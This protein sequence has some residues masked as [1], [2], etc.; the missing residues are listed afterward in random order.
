MNE[1][2][3]IYIGGLE[4]YITSYEHILFREPGNI[5]IGCG[6]ITT[7]QYL[8][9]L[10]NNLGYDRCP[11]D[12]LW[13]ENNIDVENV[14]KTEV[15]D[16]PITRN[17]LMII[18]NC[19]LYTLLICIKNWIKGGMERGHILNPNKSFKLPCKKDIQFYLQN[20]VKIVRSSV[21][22][23]KV[24]SWDKA[25]ILWRRLYNLNPSIDS[26]YFE[27]QLVNF[28]D[29]SKKII[30]EDGR[31]L[32][33]SVL[34]DPDILLSTIKQSEI[35]AT[36]LVH[37]R[38]NLTPIALLDEKEI[39][40]EF[41][42][43]L[44]TKIQKIITIYRNARC[45]GFVKDEYKMVKINSNYTPSLGINVNL[46]PPIYMG[47]NRQVDQS[48]I[49]EIFYQIASIPING[50]TISF[51][52]KYIDSNSLKFLDK[53]GQDNIHRL[54]TYKRLYYTIEQ[55]KSNN[56]ELLNPRDRFILSSSFYIDSDSFG[57]YSKKMNKFYIVSRDLILREMDPI[58]AVEYYQNFLGKKVELDPS[59]IG[60]ALEPK[61]VPY[62]DLDQLEQR[63]LG[64]IGNVIRVDQTPNI[65]YPQINFGIPREEY[66][67][68]VNTMVE[69]F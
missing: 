11:K 39:I 13:L 48:I 1:I 8:S 62:I 43:L 57:L 36:L 27:Y 32:F 50:D 38:H 64:H 66:G 59:E 53:M 16:Y 12:F 28:I 26:D 9:C 18:K 33:I 30:I 46:M 67:F 25:D 15:L 3:K 6:P 65:I 4:R 56:P 10:F 63:S 29:I 20:R 22:Y 5:E 24:E 61:S 54:A 35:E 34:I 19:D 51:I 41:E 60:T 49:G 7:H 45:K 58:E 14:E 23:P 17:P 31:P 42:R 21:L 55:L 69:N 52:T 68:D 40:I 2:Y 47:Q 37:N 44:L